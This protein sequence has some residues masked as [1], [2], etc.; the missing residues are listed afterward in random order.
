V[1]LMGQ[2]ERVAGAVGLPLDA[3]SGL[4]RAA[5]DDAMALGPE[6]ALT[7]PAARGD[8]G[9]IARHRVVLSGMV[10][11]SSELEAYD[12]MVGL[13]R[14]L[15]GEPAVAAEPAP[16]VAASRAVRDAA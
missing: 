2:V 5:V 11:G 10:Q 6:A 16:A 3:F 14:R 9:T 7:G 8:W 13:A 12:A 4:V 15:V 1:A